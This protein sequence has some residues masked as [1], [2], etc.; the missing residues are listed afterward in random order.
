MSVNLPY[1]NIR[2][3]GMHFPFSW[4]HNL[5]ISDA[6]REHFWSKSPKV[7]KLPISR[8][9]PFRLVDEYN[10]KVFLYTWPFSFRG[11][12]VE[13]TVVDC[14][15]LNQSSKLFYVLSASD[16]TAVLVTKEQT[17]WRSHSYNCLFTFAWMC[18]LKDAG[19]E[20][21]MPSDQ[22]LSLIFFHTHVFE[23][24]P[25]AIFRFLN[26]DFFG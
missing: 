16:I 20:F 15:L 7:R 6:F 4:Y 14:V 2:S 23:C 9:D 22:N 26:F 1:P 5:L 21:E 10:F 24:S 19:R 12:L 13:D 8:T 3:Y 25:S 17:Y 11:V 18:L